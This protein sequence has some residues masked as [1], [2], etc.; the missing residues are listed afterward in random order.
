MGYFVSR[1]DLIP[2]VNSIRR[3]KKIGLTGGVFDIF[4]AGHADFL[5]Q[6]KSMCDVL[7]V[8]VNS[9]ESVKIIKGPFRPIINEVNRIE[10]ISSCM[11]VD[12]CFLFDEKNQ[13][14]NLNLIKPYFFFKGADYD[15]EKLNQ[16]DNIEAL[17]FRPEIVFIERKIN[18]ST[19][20]I[21]RKILDLGSN[22]QLK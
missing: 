9:D 8:A 17:S 14:Q 7:I 19:T 2:I 20:G 4:H 18:L 22:L 12:F 15:F 16:I 3:K 5:K 13:F 10:V 1:D 21:I 11:F 6:C